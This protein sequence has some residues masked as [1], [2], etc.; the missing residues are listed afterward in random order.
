MVDWER[1]IFCALLTGRVPADREV[2]NQRL[3]GMNV[4]AIGQGALF[5][6]AG[7]LPTNSQFPPQYWK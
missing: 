3:R 6:A 1:K 7:E 4:E 5:V 2:L